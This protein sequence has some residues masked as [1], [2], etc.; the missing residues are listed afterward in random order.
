MISGESEGVRTW[1][2]GGW[3]FFAGLVSGYRAQDAVDGRR[4]ALIDMHWQ[5]R[6][7]FGINAK[8]LCRNI[9]CGPARML[10]LLFHRVHK[11]FLPIRASPSLTQKACSSEMAKVRRPIPPV[12]T[13]GPRSRSDR[14]L[15]PA[16]PRRRQ[17]QRIAIAIACPAE[18]QGSQIYCRR[19]DQPHRGPARITCGETIETE[20]RFRGPSCRGARGWRSASPG[21]TGS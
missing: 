19:S 15:A 9:A 1:F 3:S 17:A 14:P 20:S 11:G 4:L 2:L 16:D 13:P 12:S 5:T 21:W 18:H 7:P 10:Q 6:G 8:Y